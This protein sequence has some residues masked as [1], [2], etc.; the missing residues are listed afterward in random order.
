MAVVCVM[1]VETYSLMYR[2]VESTP[3]SEIALILGASVLR[4]G[5]LSGVFEDRA[6]A[7]I[8]LYEAGKVKKILVTGDNSTLS[9][10]E[11][12]PARKY[13]L[14]KGIPDGDIFLDHAGFDTYSSIY[15]A[16]DIFKVSSV[17]IVTQSFHLPRALFIAKHLGIDAVGFNADRGYYRLK[18]YVREWFA[19]VKALI[20]LW[21]HREPRYLGE[22]IPIQGEAKS[23][24]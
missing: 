24:L 2:T 5:N 19:D 4:N 22:E 15:R 18:N 9:Y 13:L 11:V 17:I 7:A 23:K 12:N 16:R 21:S 8:K 10:N 20:D 1:K 14:A 3:S 6:L